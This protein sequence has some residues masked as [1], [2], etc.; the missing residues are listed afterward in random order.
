MKRSYPMPIQLDKVNTS[1]CWKFKNYFFGHDVTF[2]AMYL[3]ELADR[4]GNGP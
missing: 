1:K 3:I 2:W 4:R